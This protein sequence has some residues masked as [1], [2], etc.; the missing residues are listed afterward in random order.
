MANGV[1]EFLIQNDL[2]VEAGVQPGQDPGFE[3]MTMVRNMGP[4]LKKN[5]GDLVQA[6]SHP[7]QTGQGLMGTVGG[8]ASKGGIPGLSQFEPY[9]DAMNEFFVD[10]YGSKEAFLNTV[11]T[12]PAGA[13]LDLS[14]VFTGGGGLIRGGG[15]VASTASKT[16]SAVN[17]V[18][19]TVNQAGQNIQRA[20]NLIDPINQGL[21]L[22]YGTVGSLIP[23]S[24]PESLYA[25]GMKP[26]TTLSPDQR[27]TILRTGVEESL[28]PNQAGLTRLGELITDYG[29][30]VDRLIRE[31][32]DSG[33]TVDATSLF[34]DLANLEQKL[35]AGNN[36]TKQADLAEVARVR[37]ELAESIYG[38]G[39]EDLDATV[40]PRRLNAEE[41]QQ[42]KRSAYAN[43]NYGKRTQAPD[44]R[45][46]AQQAIGRSARQQ[47]ENITTPEIAEYNRRLGNLLET[48]VPLERAANRVGQ[49]NAL[50]LPAIIAGSS[51]LASGNPF[52]AL[53][54]GGLGSLIT[55]TN[56][57]R[58]GI[59]LERM[60]QIPRQGML[61][62]ETLLDPA[63]GRG[64]A[65]G[66]TY[67]GRLQ[68]GLQRRGLLGR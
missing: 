25:S 45:N 24:V 40:P 4:S 51:G 19:Q 54:G 39:I 26:G 28:M 21:K 65:R 13:L 6:V 63:L 5:I 60:R 62:W 17:R 68:E 44:L 66:A 31:S 30:A 55:P 67:G 29:D 34:S 18:A 61:N 15:A 47:V 12:D 3:F 53:L 14:T 56:Q 58:V 49:R 38:I 23:E 37:S 46:E 22:G 20:G 57:S 59:G 7:I 48:Q 36:I 16:G 1:E 10:R 33:Q 42:V 50:S 64:T 9:A 52:T 11:E 2:M 8:Y 43:A 27:K 35:M 41:L 32:V